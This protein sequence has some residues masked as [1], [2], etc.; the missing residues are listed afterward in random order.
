MR[1]MRRAHGSGT[2]FTK[3]TKTTKNFVI[4]VILVIFV[5]RPSAVGVS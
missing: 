2:K 1:T 4:F 5:T 3:N